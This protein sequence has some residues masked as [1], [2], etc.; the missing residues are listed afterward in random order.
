MS[1]NNPAKLRAAEAAAELVK[2]GIVVGLGSG[3]TATAMVAR[4]GERIVA[5]RLTF[6][7]VPTSKA[8]A[9]LA[10]SVGIEVRDLD[11]VDMID[12]NLDGADEIDLGYNMIKGR[13][14]ALLREKL[15]VSNAVKRVTI[16]TAEKR[17]G[18]LGQS[19]PVPVEVSPF[20]LQH[21]MRH[22]RGL[23]CETRLRSGSD[24]APF[25]TD[26]GHHIVDCNFGPI[27]DPAGLERQLKRVA[28]VL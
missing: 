14:G 1:E 3:N 22:L 5:E 12:L 27:D 23:G 16:I 13:G 20:G 10:R 11:E 24:G 26:G 17:V 28:V 8:T 19:M 6:V 21:V 9:S 2:P 25:V 15:V 18:R 7:G 4:L